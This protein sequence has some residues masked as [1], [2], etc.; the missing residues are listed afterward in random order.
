MKDKN[1]YIALI[2]KEQFFFCTAVG[3]GGGEFLSK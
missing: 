3:G 2:R 1:H